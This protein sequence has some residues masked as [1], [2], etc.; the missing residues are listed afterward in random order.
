MQE[1]VTWQRKRFYLSVS[2]VDLQHQNGWENV[3][4]VVLGTLLLS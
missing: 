4:I 3:Q 1:G 2:I